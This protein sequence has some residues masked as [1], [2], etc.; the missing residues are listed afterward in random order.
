M[1][2]ESPDFGKARDFYTFA[3]ETLAAELP[4][5]DLIREVGKGSMGIV[6]E[7]RQKDNGRIVALK[8]LP[9]S[10]TLTERA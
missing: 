10:L 9:P 8:V 3:P 6:F 5:F 7:A 1:S 2:G 4:A